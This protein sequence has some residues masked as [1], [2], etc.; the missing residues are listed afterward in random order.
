MIKAIL[1]DFDGVLTID[2]TGSESIINYIAY[3]CSIHKKIIKK[4]YYRF[5]RSLLNGELT[6]QDIWQS[7][8]E[9]VGQKLNYDILIEA[10]ENTKLDNDMIAYLKELKLKYLIGMVTDNKVDRIDTILEFY[11][12]KQ[13]FDIVSISAKTHSGKDEKFIF[14]ETVSKLSV[15]PDEC[16]FIDNTEKNLVIPK[17][18][19]MRTILFDDE[20]RSIL[21][22]KQ[23]LESFLL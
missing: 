15:L 22:F 5:N 6:H 4:S 11:N 2:K 17:K 12:L 3:E 9:D 1:F 13:Y 16:V 20:D 14:E 7:F 19:G 10:F 18:M 8:C 21:K 23:E